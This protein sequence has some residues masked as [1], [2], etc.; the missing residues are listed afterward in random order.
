[1]AR[2]GDW[3]SAAEARRIALAAQGLDESRPSGPPRSRHLLRTL[4]RLGLL[5][6]DSVN[7]LVRAHYLPLFSR[8]GAYDR[9]LLD[10]SAYGGFRRT[11]FEYWG[12]EASLLPIGLHPLLRW[13]MERAGRGLGLYSGLARF[14]RDRRAFVQAALAEVTDR[15]PLAAS[16]LSNG[17]RGRGSW[18]GWSEG[19]AALEWLFWAGLVTTASRRGF[20]RVYDL[21]ARCLPPEVLAAPTPPEDVAQRALLSL[22]ARALGVAT[23]RDLRDYFRLDVADTR[24][25]LAEMLEAG[26]LRAVQVEGWTQPAYLHPEARI[27]RQV[28]A[29]ALLVPFDPL[30]WERQRTERVF[31]FHYRIEIYTPAAQRR[32]GYY[33]LPF[34]LGDRL[35]ARVDLKSDRAAGRLRVVAAH[36]EAGVDAR[37]VAPALMLELRDMAAWLGLPGVDVRGRGGLGVALRACATAERATGGSGR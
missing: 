25:R 31:G 27:P 6:I 19:K 37:R 33:V 36:V 22:A 16:D 26:D 10:A 7:V 30:V 35:V 29:R 8:L 28:D 9:T 12:H 34:L 14:G 11:V 13:R 23:E 18:W 4:G 24:A 1:V 17:G 20:E 32:H 5:Q 2:R 15:G 3:L 21:P